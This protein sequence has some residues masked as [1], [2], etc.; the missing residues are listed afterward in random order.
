MAPAA[1]TRRGFLTGALGVGAALGFTACGSNAADGTAPAAG[2][3]IAPSITVAPSPAGTPGS[4]ATP[5][6]SFRLFTDESM[7]FDALFGLGEST[8][9][10]SEAGEVITAV[11]QANAAG[12]DYDGYV[13]AFRAMGDRVATASDAATAAGDHVTARDT[14][15]RAASYYTRAL[16]F[17]LGTA[18]P[19]AEMPLYAEYRRAWD[20]GIAGAGLA[21]GARPAAEVLDI[22]YGDGGLRAWLFRP[23]DSG[24]ARRTVII[25]N[26]SDAQGVELI[27]YGVR[28]AL[29]RDWNALVFEGPG[30][31]AMLFERGIP[32]R[33]DWE[34]VITP[35]VDLL[36]GRDDVDPNA[37]ALTGWSMG[38]ELVARAAA[39]EHRLVA[40]VA[41][42]P[43]VDMWRTLPDQVRKIVDPGDPFRTNLIWNETIVPGMTPEQ[44][45]TVAKRMEIY[46][47]EAHDAALG[48]HPTRDFAA[49]AAQM[50]KFTVTDAAPQIRC[51]TLVLDYEGE[52][53]YPGQPA[54][55]LSLLTA[56]AKMVTLTAADGAQYHCAPMAPA[57]RNEVV[58]DWLDSV[59]PA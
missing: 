36:S 54:E 1:A 16:F 12:A 3:P 26:G 11:N 37:I 55:F 34:A 6:P 49:V 8:Y 29:D 46:T 42:P 51:P 14:A 41:D 4:G 38:G 47:P 2:G 19:P 7:N 56:D 18:A 58:F 23:D 45:F 35:V 39:Y 32:F 9:G 10:I 24:S 25:N 52:S 40:L 44:R 22:P 28:A 30:Q 13:T 33:P 5:F 31:G 27:A 57:R 59:V 20:R 17:V 15:L 53:F 43:A 21:I 48:G 50:K